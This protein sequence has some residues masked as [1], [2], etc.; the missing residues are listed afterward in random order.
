MMSKINIQN[1]NLVSLKDLMVYYHYQWIH[2]F[3][4]ICF[5]VHMGTIEAETAMT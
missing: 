2:L 1:E 3:P 5:I 4:D